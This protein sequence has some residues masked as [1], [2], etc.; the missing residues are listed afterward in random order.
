MI[1]EREAAKY[2]FLKEAEKLVEVLDLTLEDMANPNLKQAIYRAEQRVTQ[3]I[4]NGKASIN[5]IDSLTE[6]LSYPI[7]NIFVMAIND[8]FLRRRYSL[9]EAARA[10]EL[11]KE[12]NEVRIAKI[13]RSEF[14]WNLRILREILDGR[15]Y[16][17][18]LYFTNYLKN[19]SAFREDKWKLVNKLVRNGYV[20]ITKSDAIRLLQEE[21]QRSIADL[22]SKPKKLTLSDSLQ[23]RVNKIKEIFEKNREKLIGRELPS[24][25]VKTGL[26]PCMRRAYDGLL[27]GRRASHMERFA[28]TSFLIN[29]GMNIDEIINLF[30]SV[31]DFDE[32]FTRYQVEHIAGLRGSRTKY[33]PPTCSTLKTHK[34]CYNPDQLCKK[35]KHP[36]SYYRRKV[37]DE[38]T[39][40][41]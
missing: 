39:T 26:P 27:S 13:A 2:P 20:L 8:S 25:I 33:T 29:A 1:T 28:L 37:R 38:M 4:E 7:A 3:A 16:S 18:E 23:V 17:F 22:F 11:L 32:Q 9:S 21:I 5:L 15:L 41:R 24:I 10:H 35:I 40:R 30:I 19:S 14:N 12:E 34:V 31:T 36:L 6:L